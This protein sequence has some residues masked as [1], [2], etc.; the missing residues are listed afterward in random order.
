MEI[1]VYLF[2]GFLEAGKTTFIQ[3]TLE[4]ER[5]NQGENTLLLICEEGIEDYA[6]DAFSGARVFLETVENAEDLTAERL[7][8]LC[9]KHACE[10]V[11]VEY[12]GMWMLDSL[13][14]AL[15]EEWMVY[16]E[17]LFVDARTFLSY[18]ANMRERVVDKLKS[19]EMV[20]FTRADEATDRMVFHQIV[21]GVSR[22]C[23]IAYEDAQGNVS[24]DDI[25]DE[26][27]FDINAP[28][29]EV[30]QENYATWYR[31]ISE[32][33]EKYE[34]KTV[35]LSGSVVIQDRLPENSFIFGRP[36]MTCCADDVAFAGVLCAAKSRKGLSNEDWVTLT[37]K[38]SVQDSEVY[39]R[40]GPVFSV[41]SMEKGTAPENDVATFY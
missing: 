15:P 18:N 4:D 8:G 40:R 29:I 7:E 28:V 19:C 13:Y 35:Q 39:G 26:L 5:F 23:E 34:G 41:I 1:P 30:A 32:E 16:Q 22:R 31:D 36:V 11:I 21:R 27:P 38:I 2:T 10:R 33:M 6:P 17:F 9:K 25:P 37:A 12:N 3:K 14:N 24:Y 20:V